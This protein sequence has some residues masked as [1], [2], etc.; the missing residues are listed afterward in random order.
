MAEASS[1]QPSPSQYSVAYVTAPSE[2]VAK[3]LS[4]GLV[5][6]KL[7]ACVNIVP[8]ITSIYEWKGEINEDN[9]VLMIIK[10]R[11]SRVL[12]LTDF[13]KKNHPYEVCEVISTEKINGAREKLEIAENVYN[14]F[15]IVLL[16]E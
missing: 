7:A 16:A 1:F 13:V 5:K 11:T 15:D 6:E 12:E 9:E 10:T 4:R 2:D 3:E 14:N 8:K